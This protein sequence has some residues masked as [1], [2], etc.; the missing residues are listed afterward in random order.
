MATVMCG[1]KNGSALLA[2]GGWDR[3]V[4]K[5]PRWETK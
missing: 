4:C 3:K 1:W 5:A 2:I